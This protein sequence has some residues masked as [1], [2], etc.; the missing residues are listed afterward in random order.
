MEGAFTG[1]IK[2]GKIGKFEL[3]NKGTLF[4]DEIGDM[5][6]EMQAK[7]LR[8]LQDGVIYRL[9]SE[10]S[11]ITNTRIISATNK[12]LNEL[13]SEGKFREDL[14]YRLAVVQIKLPDL[15][16]RREDIRDLS[17][18]FFRQ[19]SKDEGI[20]INYIDEKIYKILADYKWDGNIRELKNVIQRMVVLSNDGK[21]TVKSIPEY[22]RNENIR[23]YE[24]NDENKYD[25]QITENIERKTIEKVM[26]MVHGNKNKAAKILNIKRSTLYYKLSKFK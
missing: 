20:E 18:L 21:I 2:K 13:I 24:Y 11:I 6:M 16:D 10:K 26:K 9:G 12:N 17:N 19:V 3:A 14:F 4:L 25:L 23:N 7:L 5:P 22:I 1:A 15:K 8:V